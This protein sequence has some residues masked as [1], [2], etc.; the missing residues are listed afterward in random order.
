M[1]TPAAL[2]LA[3]L[4]S[5][6]VLVAGCSSDGSDDAAEETTTTEAASEETDGPD[7]ERANPD[8]TDEPVT[9]VDVSEEEYVAALTENLSSGDEAA[10]QL[11]LDAGAAECIAPLWVEAMTVELLQ[12]RGVTVEDL[13]DPGFDGEALG[14]ELSQG[15]DMVAAFGACDVD[16]VEL[17]STALTQGLEPEQ[18]ECVQANADE[19]L[20]EALLA[21]SFSGAGSDTEFETLI[22]QLTESCDLPG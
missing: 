3:L 17:F 21:A 10:G 16:V 9:P 13:S 5:A 11:V 15:E 8:A 2:L 18:Q 12:E 22:G 7:D 14:M 4:L 20:V 1:R 6:S 19:E